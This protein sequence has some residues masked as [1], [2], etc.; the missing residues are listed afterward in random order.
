MMIIWGTAALFVGIVSMDVGGAEALGPSAL[1]SNSWQVIGMC[2][3]CSSVQSYA[4]D[5]ATTKSLPD[6]PQLPGARGK[7]RNLHAVFGILGCAACFYGYYAI[8]KALAASGTSLFIAP[9]FMQQVHVV[10]GYF[11]LF[12][13][14]IQSFSGVAKYVD[15]MLISEKVGVPKYVK[16]MWHGKGYGIVI[17]GM[18]NM[19]FS[20]QFWTFDLGLKCVM[21]VALVLT[22]TA[23]VLPGFSRQRGWKIYKHIGPPPALPQAVVAPPPA[24]KVVVAQEE[25]AALVPPLKEP[26]LPRQVSGGP[27][28]DPAESKTK[29]GNLVPGKEASFDDIENKWDQVMSPRVNPLGGEK[30]MGIPKNEQIQNERIMGA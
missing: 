2:F 26:L 17:L 8:Y 20:L 1:F 14:A 24:T 11:V 9:T 7:A 21:F 19:I 25:K 10:L 22:L 18:L 30:A 13:I 6:H 16:M 3:I 23:A 27:E 29:S 12:L 4:L 15:K 28:L 5:D